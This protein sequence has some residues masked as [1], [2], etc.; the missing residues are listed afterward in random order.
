MMIWGDT[1]KASGRRSWQR[2][3]RECTRPRDSCCAAQL[4][5]TADEREMII[6]ENSPVLSRLVT[7][8]VV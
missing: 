3:K 8:E 1:V 4:E 5:W 6:A 7:D 2:C